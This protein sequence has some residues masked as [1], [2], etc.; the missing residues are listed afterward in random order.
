MKAPAGSEKPPLPMIYILDPSVEVTG[1]FICARTEAAL[2]HNDARVALALPDR[3]SIEDRD[4]RPFAKVVRLPIV[5]LRKSLSSVLLY[6]PSLIVA[7]WRLRR[8]MAADE[9]AVLQV[10]DF[11]LMHGALCRLLGFRGRIVT[12]VRFDPRR[13][14]P[15]LSR[16]WLGAAR[17]ASDRIVAVSR[18]IKDTLP[19]GT[20]A[21]VV[22]DTVPGGTAPAPGGQEKHGGGAR[23][24]AFIGN[25]IDGKGQNDAIEA[26]TPVARANADLE[27][28]FFGSDMGLDRNRGYRERLEARAAALGLDD[29]IRFHGFIEDP[30]AVLRS[31]YAA[32]NFSRS[33]SFSM[34]CLEA[35]YCG[36]PMVATNS[37]GPAEIIDDGA[38]G[39]LVPVGDIEA[40]S[41]AIRQLAEDPALAA[42]M[43]ERAARLTR[44]RFS[45][46]RFLREVKEVLGL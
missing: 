29:R 37:G 24:F 34:T 4:L 11:Y 40:M 28:H 31:A 12:W 21:T 35:G 20:E 19:S 46:D 18:F 42:A 44:E 7:S 14:G 3:A 36:V 43:G 45:P 8:E 6:L 1:A 26:F 5:N 25:Y 13:F 33:E 30:A 16:L 2:L 39:L 38:S 22:Y 41:D 17:L 10:N 15:V 23:V 9:A 32:L 27:L